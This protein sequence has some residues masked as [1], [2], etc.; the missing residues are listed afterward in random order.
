MRK[1]CRGLS[2]TIALTLVLGLSGCHLPQMR[3]NERVEYSFF[4]TFPDAV[5]PPNA[6]SL[7]V[8]LFEADP[9]FERENFVFRLGEERWETDFYRAF[10]DPPATLLTFATRRWMARSGLFSMV[11]IPGLG[12]TG[13]WQLEGFVNRIYADYRDSA[14]PR[15]VLEM[16]FSLFPPGSTRTSTPV[17][18]RTYSEVNSLEVNSP[19]GLVAAW[20]GGFENIMRRLVNDLR[21]VLAQAPNAH[22]PAE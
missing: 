2:G 17:L 14:Q 1:I 19:Q 18:S 22:S 21:P 6:P 10:A 3:T 8:R 20:S 12:T 16:K 4:P 7:A 11:S 13:N 15:A 9:Q 5:A